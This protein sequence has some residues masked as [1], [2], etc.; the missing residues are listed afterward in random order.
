[1]SLLIKREFY[2]DM[3][4]TYHDLSDF[5]HDFYDELSEE[6]YEELNKIRGSL[7]VLVVKTADGLGGEI[8]EM[9]EERTSKLL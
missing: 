2:E 8:F 5:L 3:V 1:M 7:S 9:D 4:K 6:Q